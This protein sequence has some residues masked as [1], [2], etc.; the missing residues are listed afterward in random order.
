MPSKPSALYKT[1]T[2]LSKGLQE[3]LVALEAGSIYIGV[4]ACP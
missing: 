2:E 4:P 3:Q 1:Q